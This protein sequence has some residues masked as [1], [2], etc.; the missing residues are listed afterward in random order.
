MDSRASGATSATALERHILKSYSTLRWV[1]AALGFLLP[2]F[3]TICGVMKLWWLDEQLP[4][5]TSL[6]AYYHAGGG[7]ATSYGVYRNLFVG[8]LCVI[9]ACL[10]IYSG[11][12]DF[13]DRLLNLAGISLLLV[14]VF[15]TDWGVADLGEQCKDFVPFTAS[16]ILGTSVPIHYA[17]AIAFFIFIALVNVCTAYDSVRMIKDD[18]VRNSWFA[19]YRIARWLMPLA[20]IVSALASRFFDPSRTVLW[21]EWGG[22]YAF[23]FYWA[24]KSFEIMGTKVDYDM[25]SGQINFATNANRKIVRTD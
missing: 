9:A 5:Q 11:F 8:I 23:S 7:C 19:I 18:K 13:E 24:L 17:A 1:M 6:S 2:P 20:L 14:A 22:I 21:V 10:V 15:P 3:L 16:K 25:V 12:S 4:I